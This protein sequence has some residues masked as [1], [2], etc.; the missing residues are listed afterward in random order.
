MVIC[1]ARGSSQK[2]AAAD[3]SSSCAAVV[4]LF[5]MSKTLRKHLDG[6]LHFVQLAE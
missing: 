5:A 3:C 6:L 2:A 1:A 4:S